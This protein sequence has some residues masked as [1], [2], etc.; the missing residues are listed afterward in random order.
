[1]FQW[2]WSITTAGLSGQGW[3]CVHTRVSAFLGHFKFWKGICKEASWIG[4]KIGPLQPILAA[5]RYV[6]FF[7]V[8][9]YKIKLLIQQLVLFL[10]IL[11]VST[12]FGR[13]LNVGQ[14]RRFGVSRGR[15]QRTERQLETFLGATHRQKIRNLPDIGLQRRCNG[16]S[17]R[18]RLHQNF[19]IPCI[20]ASP[21]WVAT[22]ANAKVVWLSRDKIL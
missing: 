1:M 9:L 7:W 22:K 16:W 18:F 8:T 12:M 15:V 10:S 14:P 4:L 20:H 17:S 6:S 3:N 21:N 11:C 2:R 19:N 5:K 13:K